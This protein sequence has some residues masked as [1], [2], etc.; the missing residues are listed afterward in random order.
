M[1]TLFVI[2][3]AAG[4]GFVL[5]SRRSSAGIPLAYFLGLSLIHVP[6]AMLDLGITDVSLNA[7]ATRV[8][9]EQTVI[10]MVAFLC[11][12]MI[13][14]FTAFAQR[15]GLRV[16]VEAPRVLLSRDQAAAV[17][18]RALLYF[19]LGGIAYFLL[20]P[21]LGGVATVTAVIA[22]LGS[23]IIVGLCL[24]LWVAR[25]TGKFLKFWLTIVLLPVLPAVVVVQSGAIGYGTYWILAILSFVFCQSKRRFG[26][27]L[28][29][30]AVIYIGLSVFVSYMA[31]RNE[32]RA[33]VWHSKTEV[34]DRILP[35]EDAIL[36]S[37]AWFDASNL[38]QRQLIASRLNQN[39]FTGVAARRFDSGQQD[40]A[41]G[42]TLG[43]MMMALIPRAVWPDK[44]TVGGGGTVVHVFTGIKF[45]A[46]TSVGAGQVFEFYVNFGTLGVIGGFL[47]LGWLLGRMDLKVIESLYRGDQR[48]FL[49]W[50]LICLS[51]LNPG[52]N[53]LE[54]EVSAAS[55][56][57]TAYGLGR[58]LNRFGKLVNRRERADEIVGV[59]RATAAN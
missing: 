3:C 59:P 46:G 31:A 52:G 39:L 45:A 22:S 28:I 51:L 20:L 34:G 56:A 16:F 54:I 48:R 9:F 25:E 6:G 26:Y 23:L 40:Y 13:A 33:I 10:G 53:L 37:L 5:V 8:G 30:P 2:W 15:P 35:V 50:F 18:R 36:R 42:A 12:V 41:R 49:F 38:R 1:L 32:I 29:A 19:G 4:I 58:L 55:S 14:R 27:V 24:W 11:G 43:T 44:P 7:L 57:I 47:L 21:L 17:D